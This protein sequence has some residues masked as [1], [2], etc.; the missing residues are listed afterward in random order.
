MKGITEGLDQTCE[1][2]FRPCFSP[3]WENAEE[4]KRESVCIHLV[5][6]FD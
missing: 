2:N 1:V 3:F 4:M 5:F 6:C